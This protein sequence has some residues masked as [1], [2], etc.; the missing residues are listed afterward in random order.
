MI[1]SGFLRYTENKITSYLGHA[2][3]APA[4]TNSVRL[5]KS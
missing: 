4:L 3:E 1:F 5:K 2:K